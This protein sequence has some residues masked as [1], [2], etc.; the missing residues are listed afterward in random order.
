MRQPLWLKLGR[1]YQN[2]SVV[3]KPRWYICQ[4]LGSCDLS[5][6][7]LVSMCWVLIDEDYILHRL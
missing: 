5:D 4:G 1:Y 6:G 2:F 3:S 7:Y